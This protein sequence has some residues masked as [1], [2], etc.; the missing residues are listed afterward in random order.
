MDNKEDLVEGISLNELQPLTEQKKEMIKRAKAMPITFDHDSPE[1]TPEPLQRF[2]LAAARRN[3]NREF[4]EK[5]QHSYMQS[6]SGEGKPIEDVFDQLEK[7]SD[8][9]SVKS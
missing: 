3:K 8:E 4:D 1:S 5:L 2:A 6:L 7:F 9:T